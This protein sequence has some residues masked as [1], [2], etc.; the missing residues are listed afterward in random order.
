MRKLTEWS[1]RFR[2]L[3]L[4]LALLML[5]LGVYA[6]AALQQ[7]LLPNIELPVA[8]ILTRLPG[9][10]TTETLGGV[11]VPLEQAAQKSSDV[12]NVQS[13][14][15]PGMSAVVVLAD[16]GKSGDELS[17]QLEGLVGEVTL[18]PGAETE[19]LQMNIQS[20]PVIQA[21]ASGDVPLSELQPIVMDEIVPRLE[22]LE[23]VSAVE[24]IGGLDE[25]APAAPAT[26]GQGVDLPASWVTAAAMR[27]FVLEKTGDLTPEVIQG[28]VQM[29]PQ[30]LDELTPEM[31][32]DLPANVI[33]ALPEEFVAKLD[34]D[35][36]AGLEERLSA[37]PA[38]SEPVT[39]P[40][41]WQMAGAA[42]GVALNTTAD[43]RPEIIQ[44]VAQLAP[45][46]LD[47]L[48][49]EMLLAFPADV[50][51]ALPD[52]YLETLDTDLRDQLAALAGA[53]PEASAP[54]ASVINRTNGQPSL[55][56]SVSK[57]RD[58]NTVAVVHRVEDELEKLAEEIPTVRFST[59]FE[60]A[61]FI[62]ESIS[63]VVREG[64]LG[65]L[66]AVF[67]ILVFLN[68]SVRSTLVVAVSIP[69]SV[70]IAFVLLNTQSLTLNMMTLGGMTVAIG[71]VID[72]SI[73]VLENIYRHIQR[74]EDRRDAV[75][76]GT[77]DVNM[78]ILAST[79]TT[80]A[81]FLPL[82]MVGG[83]VGQAFL[84]FALTVTFAL[85]ASYFV[86]VTVVPVLAYTFIRKEHLP[87][88]KETWLQRFYTPILEWALGH[89]GLILAGAG[90]L[91]VV[92]IFLIQFIPL[93]FIPEV[94]EATIQINLDMPPGTDMAVTDQVAQQIEEAL[95]DLGCVC[96][97][98]TVV[99]GGGSGMASMLGGNSVNPT[100]ANISVSLEDGKDI[101]AATRE[102][103]AAAER[104]AGAENV[105]VTSGGSTFGANF[106]AIDLV[107]TADRYEDLEAVNEA[108]L[109]TLEDVEGLV[110][111]GSD[112]GLAGG[113]NGMITRIDGKQ[114]I[115]FSAEIEG[116]DTMRVSAKAKQAVQ[117]LPNLPAGVEVSEGFV[118][119]Q[120]TAGFQDMGV[121]MVIAIAIVYAILALT[122]RSLIHPF[123]ILFSLPLAAI[124]A[125]WA[126][127][128]TGRVLG[129]SSMIGMLMLIGIVVTNAIVL[130]DRVQRNRK[131]RGMV[132]YDA[133]VEAGRTRL[134]PILMTAIAAI[135]ALV[136][137]AL[138]LT[139]G[140]II[141]SELA[142]VVIGGLFTSTFLTLL[143]V[144]TVYSLVDEFGSRF[145]AR[146]RRPAA[147]PVTSD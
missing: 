64:A 117:A 31:L 95:A 62:E 29:A 141:A 25:T 42:Q 66:F 134:R 96:T 102:I 4:I 128:L 17:S 82:G 71:R 111:V 43:L 91:L 125:V 5:G 146:L 34:A 11:T 86:A 27:G 142:T 15:S 98:Q 65:A 101:D 21:S 106:G 51:G 127:F 143:V 116:E 36:Q 118:S 97:L 121:A 130:I 123:T 10:S 140:A 57:T 45:Q 24:V 89:R 54:P 129:I 41:S 46:M 47:E 113:A 115:S 23:G 104:I 135:L 33:P 103:R 81:V 39:L 85:A 52:S 99:G 8:T 108:V 6:A 37:G 109:A 112:L 145:S 122:F 114:A 110:N 26:A 32:L 79:A 136:P 100:Q 105:T 69:L 14:S 63:G 22:A 30:M 38:A 7:E 94:G 1:L 147:A 44:G 84:P 13:I 74:G 70:F 138:G 132:T 73:V 59:V 20:L 78:A 83:I 12:L 80:V 18:P 131:E 133:L 61:S 137:L 19:V 53:A 107:V 50:I 16:F 90:G 126:L 49:P 119:Q 56:I 68:F 76:V 139:E 144:P 75:I 3:T 92:S 35:V 9:T 124:G 48:T 60:Q 93:A 58:A 120:Q 67:V 28:I 77:G 72:D 40:E 55:G 87:E 88:E 2:W